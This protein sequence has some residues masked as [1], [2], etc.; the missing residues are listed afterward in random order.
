[1][2]RANLVSITQGLFGATR[3]L[4]DAFRL[5]VDKGIELGIESVNA[6]EVLFGHFDGRNGLRTNVRR[7]LAG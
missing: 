4:K 6:I 7:N 2:Q 3:L 1:V 5:N